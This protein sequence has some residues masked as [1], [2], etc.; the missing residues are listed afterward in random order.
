MQDRI[1]P[2]F[3]NGSVTAVGIILGFSLSFLSQWASNPI[4]WSRVD[5]LGA[6]PLIV[7]IALQAKSFADL[8]S[9]ESLIA[10]NYD[11][12]K[13]MFLGGL[14]CV[15]AGVAIAI[16]MDVLGVGPRTLKP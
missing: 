16:M 13:S 8:M 11:R 4:A 5:L 12:A 7:G 10:A 1:S 3:R 9:R 6:V 14:G 15:A 2:E